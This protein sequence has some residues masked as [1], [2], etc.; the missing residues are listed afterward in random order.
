MVRGQLH[1]SAMKEEQIGIMLKENGMQRESYKRFE[2]D[3]RSALKKINASIRRIET[4][5][6]S[7][8]K[9][10]K[11][12]Y[13]DREDFVQDVFEIT[14]K[15]LKDVETI[16]EDHF[17]SIFWT[18]WKMMRLRSFD[19]R[20]PRTKEWKNFKP[21]DDLNEP[22]YY[23]NDLDGKLLKE[24]ADKK[25]PVISLYI[26]GH[27]FAEQARK[28]GL[29]RVAHRLRFQRELEKLKKEYSLV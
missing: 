26:N 5:R 6:S 23:M 20:D 14:F 22:D 13:L 9:T 2:F 17:L 24:I 11:Y 4:N 19:K 16:S 21:I 3:F 25:Y 10:T 29:T 18:N 1:R 27:S 8:L 12:Y 7:N 28:D 15:Y